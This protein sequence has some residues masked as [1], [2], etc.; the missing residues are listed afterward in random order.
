MKTAP[1]LPSCLLDREGVLAIAFGVIFNVSFLSCQC[2]GNMRLA[3]Q[4]G[5]EIRARNDC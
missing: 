2:L 5:L 3:E 4:Q 1:V